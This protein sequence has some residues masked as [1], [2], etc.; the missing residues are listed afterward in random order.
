MPAPKPGAGHP[1]PSHRRSSQPIFFSTPLF[2]STPRARPQP[3]GGHPSLSPRRPR[4]PIFFSTSLFSFPPPAWSRPQ[5][6][7]GR[8]RTSPNPAR[9][10]TAVDEPETLTQTQ[11]PNPSYACAYVDPTGRGVLPK[12]PLFFSTSLFSFP[13]PARPAPRPHGGGEKKGG[14]VC[15]KNHTLG[16]RRP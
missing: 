10:G 5:G 14:G 13:P 6:R 9:G 7:E 11:N 4:Q 15:G 2:F 1:A 8:G 16:G 3:G 12:L